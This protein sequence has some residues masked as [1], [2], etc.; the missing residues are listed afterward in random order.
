MRVSIWPTRMH[1][2]PRWRVSANE[3]FDFQHGIRAQYS[4]DSDFRKFPSLSLQD[5]FSEQ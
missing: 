4:A 1:C 5:P 3:L 2:M